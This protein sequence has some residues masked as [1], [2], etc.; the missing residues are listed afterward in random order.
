MNEA[1]KQ[2]LAAVERLMTFMPKETRSVLLTPPSSEEAA[3]LLNQAEAFATDYVS[4]S[5]ILQSEESKRAAALMVKEIYIEGAVWATHTLQL[6]E[7]RRL[8]RLVSGHV[9]ASG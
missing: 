9:E 6:R 5:R 1:Q 3:A 7:L 2:F 8:E 4:F